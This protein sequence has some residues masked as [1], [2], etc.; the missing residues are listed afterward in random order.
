MVGGGGG[1]TIMETYIIFYFFY[2]NLPLAASFSDKLSFKVDMTFKNILIFYI[3]QP[4]YIHKQ[5][6]FKMANYNI[7]SRSIHFKTFQSK[8][9]NFI[10]QNIGPLSIT[11]SIKSKSLI[12]WRRKILILIWMKLIGGG[13][14]KCTTEIFIK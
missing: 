13:V 4:Q 10:K 1:L 2:W 11:L 6:H 9:Q 8:T 3:S 7:I 12:I 14:G 5:I